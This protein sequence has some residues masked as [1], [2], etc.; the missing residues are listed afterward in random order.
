MRPLAVATSHANAAPRTT[1]AKTVAIR[2]PSQ[3][4]GGGA[5]RVA[6]TRSDNRPMGEMKDRML[7]GEPYVADDP[8]LAADLARAQAL[9]ERYN[10]APHAEQATRDALLR[11]LLGSV[12]DGVVVRPPFRCEYGTP[13]SIGAGTFVNFDC[14]MLDVAPITFGAACQLATRVQLLTAAHPVE[15]GPRRDGWESGAPITIGDNV[16]L[17]AGAIVCPGV[18]IGDDHRRRGRGRRDRDLPA[19][20]VADGV[21][22]GSVAR[23]V[24]N[25]PARDVRPPTDAHRGGP[26]YG[27]H[28]NLALG[29][30]SPVSRP[31]PR[32]PAPRPASRDGGTITVTAQLP[33][34]DRPRDLDDDAVVPPRRLCVRRPLEHDT[35]FRFALLSA[36]LRALPGQGHVPAEEAKR[37]TAPCYLAGLRVRA[38]LDPAQSPAARAAGRAPVHRD[39]RGSLIPS[40][41][42]TAAGARTRR[43]A[44]ADRRRPLTATVLCR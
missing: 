21:P 7:R 41:A 33:G 44:R 22:A 19:G 29:S 4:P 17:G 37:A 12:G 1:T 5:A 34:R 27:R 18:T 24:R 13:I 16:W 32:P 40:S 38:G 15:P 10:A 20:V 14:I 31:P 28:E 43:G 25:P 30:R 23:W 42:A 9:L 6:A 36:I 35:R 2:R 3:V 39:Q 11:E 26:T 8:D